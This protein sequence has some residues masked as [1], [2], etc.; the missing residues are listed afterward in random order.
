MRRE[1]RK[2]VDSTKLGRFFPPPTLFWISRRLQLCRTATW[3]QS[4]VIYGVKCTV[5]LQTLE[6][7][8]LTKTLV[9]HRKRLKCE[10]AALASPRCVFWQ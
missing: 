10:N 2:G 7:N 6:K 4:P 9:V 5:E 8:L 3:Q 1:L